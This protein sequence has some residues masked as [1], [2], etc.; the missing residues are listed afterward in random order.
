MLRKLMKHEF[1]ATSRTML[2]MFLAILA[3]SL[4]MAIVVRFWDSASSKI[5]NVFSVLIAMGYGIA[6]GAVFIVVLVLM[7]QRFR[8]NLLQD[9][10]YVMFTL[11]V[12]THQLI[13]SKI[14]VSCAWFFATLL[15]VMLSG[16]LVGLLGAFDTQA[17][18]EIRQAWQ[19]FVRW[20]TLE[21]ALNGVILLLEGVILAF[22]SY[23]AMCL[24]FYGAMALGY[25]FD[26]RKGL[27]SILFLIGFMFVTQ[28][29]GASF[30]VVFDMGQFLSDIDMVQGSM[31]AFHSFFFL[32]LVLT[33]IQGAVFYILTTQMLKKRLNIE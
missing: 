15:V 7:I 33:L 8:Q 20:M 26:R 2:P 31:A 14:I 1:R 13:W 9:E 29:V 17:L 5:L 19:E 6:L 24:M 10:G 18:M 28:F 23:A 27:L 32:D 16:L 3:L 25:S 21:Y 22:F 12:N 30:L 11:P 4:L